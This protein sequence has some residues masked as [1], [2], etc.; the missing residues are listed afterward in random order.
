MVRPLETEG[1][2]NFSCDIYFKKA[3]TVVPPPSSA[4]LLSVV[5][6]PHSQLGF[7]DIAVAHRIATFRSMTDR[8]YGS[9]PMDDSEAKKISSS[10]ML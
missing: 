4:V 6:V 5:S 3:V 7:K 9:G 1:L 10:V 8:K 2:M